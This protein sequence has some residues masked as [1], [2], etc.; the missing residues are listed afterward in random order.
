MGLA[1]V[2]GGWM[3]VCF[4]SS[5]SETRISY[6]VFIEEREDDG[7]KEDPRDPDSRYRLGMILDPIRLD[8]PKHKE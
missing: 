8:E 6:T 4:C 7:T 5:T 1:D 3:T 2:R